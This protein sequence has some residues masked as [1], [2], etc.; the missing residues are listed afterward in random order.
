M[1]LTKQFEKP[2][3][4][5]EKAAQRKRRKERKNDL[6][7]VM[8]ASL[9]HTQNGCFLHDSKRPNKTSL[10][11]LS[12]SLSLSLTPSGEMNKEM[13]KAPCRNP[14]KETFLSQRERG[15]NN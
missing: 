12:L 14:L 9:T 15:V 1:E 11:L 2:H 8:L 10:V 6:K 7:G 13:R 4:R 3:T 5:T